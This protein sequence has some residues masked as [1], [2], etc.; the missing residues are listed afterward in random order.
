[1]YNLNLLILLE[2]IAIKIFHDYFHVQ[3][4]KIYKWKHISPPKQEVSQ[5]LL[6]GLVLY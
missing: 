3:G 5:N 2:K 4:P 1:M 6:Y